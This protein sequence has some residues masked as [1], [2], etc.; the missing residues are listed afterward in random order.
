MKSLFRFFALFLSMVFIVTATLLSASVYADDLIIPTPDSDRTVFYQTDF[1][2]GHVLDWTSSAGD[3]VL[4]DDTMGKAY[5]VQGY[6]YLEVENVNL[7]KEFSVEFNAKFNTEPIGQAWP[8][9]YLKSMGQPTRYEF[10]FESA[11]GQESVNLKKNLLGTVASSPLN[12][13]PDTDQWV[14]LKLDITGDTVSVYYNDTTTPVLT[15]QDPSPLDSGP[16]GFFLGG[17]KYYYIDNLLITT[18][19]PFEPEVIPPHTDNQSGG[20]YMDLNFENN[21]MAPFIDENGGAST[22]EEYDGNLALSVGQTVTAGDRSWTNCSYQFDFTLL[23]RT[24]TPDSFVP[25]K[26]AVKD[27]KNYYSLL[28]SNIGNSID[29]YQ[30]VNGAETWIGQCGIFLGTNETKHFRID[31]AENQ[32]IIYI[33]TLSYPLDL[34]WP[35][36]Q[37][38]VLDT[39]SGGLSFT[40]PAAAEKMLVDNVKVSNIQKLGE[41]GP[42]PDPVPLLEPVENPADSWTDIDGHWAADDISYLASQNMLSGYPDSLFRPEDSVAVNEFIKM[43]LSVLQI[44]VQAS[45]E[46]SW[47]APY[48]Q[49]AEKNGLIGQNDFSDFDRPITRYE[50]ARIIAKALTY[51]GETPDASVPSA[52]DDPAFQ[53]DVAAVRSAGIVTGYEDGLF[54]GEQNATRAEASVMMN[55]LQ[56]PG[57]R[58][59][60]GTVNVHPEEYPNAFRNPLKGFRG[61][62]GDKYTAVTTGSFNWDQLED[63]VNDGVDKFIAASDEAWKDYPALN[64]KV[65][66]SVVLEWPGDP[67]WPSDLTDGDYTSLEFQQRLDNFIRKMG[68]AWDND[69]RVA[70]V[71]VGLI[72]LWGEMQSPYPSF[73]VQKVLGNA[74]DKY[75]QNKKVQTNI[76]VR[77]GYMIENKV[78]IGWDSY[79]HWGNQHV[80]DFFASDENKDIWKKYPIGGETAF[81][82]GEPVGKNP[83]D[84]VANYLDRYI[85][86][87]RFTHCTYIGWISEYNKTDPTTTANAAEI[88]KILGYRFVLDQV[89][90][91]KTVNPGETME[92]SFS[93]KNTGSAPIY[94]NWPVEVSLLDPQTRQPVWSD[95]FKDLDITTWLPDDDYSYT[96]LYSAKGSFVI[97]EDL[98]AQEYILSLSILDPEGGMVPSVRFANKNYFNGGR[99][100]IGQIGIGTANTNPILSNDSFDDIDSDTSLYYVYKSPLSSS[101]S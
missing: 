61:T 93:V 68:E 53:N 44:S 58:I 85:E 13:L 69:P 21:N 63:N 77:F 17:C 38:E 27:D 48:I 99:H 65:I 66:P 75:F 26:F 54:H 34:S 56:I 91:P 94:Y 50:M 83:N 46:T 4:V 8:G 11:P 101:V 33:G 100:P 74:F 42:R 89:N 49:A 12:F 24:L 32:I 43:V 92:I 87:F 84:A 47:D 5:C 19:E 55:R 16:L 82:W 86:I 81:D 78:G 25:I 40:R 6:D 2:D 76:M 57:R 80:F 18:P 64:V 9:V 22:I 20:I 35:S 51:R 3:P 30:C 39:F 62:V 7:L 59:K 52:D 88:Q 71:R 1:E 60:P 96:P 72:G 29:V 14:Y 23:N 79:G 70:Y 73:E 15:Y 97:P 31:T 36:M 45:E 90:Y 41:I 67:H 10:F 98:P 37:L 95:T 28:F